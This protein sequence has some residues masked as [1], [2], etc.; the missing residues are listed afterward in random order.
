MA[1]ILCNH[2]HLGLGQLRSSASLAGLHLFS[3]RRLGWGGVV[4]C[5]TGGADFCWDSL[6]SIPFSARWAQTY[7]PG[8]HIGKRVILNTGR[9]L[10]ALLKSC[11]TSLG[12]FY[13]L[14]GVMGHHRF[15]GWGNKFHLLTGAVAKKMNGLFY[16]IILILNARFYLY[17]C[18]ISAW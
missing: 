13:W 8:E 12:L 18:Q 6:C 11:T 4:V 1:A 17:P 7:I 14:K 3:C 10:E 16:S 5:L 15:K 2:I 9:S